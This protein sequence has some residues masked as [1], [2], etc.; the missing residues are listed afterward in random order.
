MNLLPPSLC[1]GLLLA[2]LPILYA[3]PSEEE[4]TASEAIRAKL[5]P[6]GNFHPQPQEGIF[7]VAR[8]G[9]EVLVSRDDGKTWKQTFM[10]RPG[11][12]HGYWA[13]W[14]NIAY[15]EGVFAIAAG[16]GAPGTI[17]ASDDGEN[18]RHLADENR[19]G[20][21][22]NGNPYDMP[23]TMELIGVDGA[24]ILP[25]EA[26]PDFGKTW[27]RK[28]PYHWE[29]AAG[30][31]DIKINIGHPSLAAADY[32]EGKRVIVVGGE[33]PS[34]YSDDLGETWIAMPNV[35]VEPW[36]GRGAKGIVAKG[37]VFLILKGDGALIHRST[38][39]GMTWKAHPL[40]VTKPASRSFALS[41]VGDQFIVTGDNAK[42]S[43]DGIEWKDLPAETPKGQIA[44]SDQGTLINVNRGRNTILRSTDGENWEVVY[45]FTPAKDL[46]GAQGFADVE[47]GRVRKVT[48]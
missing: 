24:F 43:Q 18:W 12:D 35:K 2:L 45:E 34:I 16:W 26:T 32:E 8:H 27:H 11:G 42:A 37:K 48:E 39:G 46:G 7:V 13:V 10:G 14:N 1:A 30:N 3:G 36:E 31:R 40:G 21:S 5:P 29:D 17:I 25:L 15:T 44:M 19:E 33:G 38:D 41:V 4:K 23:T 22:K 47:W 20:R 28:S 6:G 9:L